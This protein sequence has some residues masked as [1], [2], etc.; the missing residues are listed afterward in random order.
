[1]SSKDVYAAFV[2]QL[3]GGDYKEYLLPNARE[4]LEYISQRDGAETMILTYGEQAFQDAKYAAVVMPLLA[5]IGVKA[6]YWSTPDKRKANF[7]REHLNSDG[8]YEFASMYGAKILQTSEIIGIGDERDDIIGCEDLPNYRAYCVK[9]PLDH[10]NRAWP[11]KD[12]L[13][14]N[15]CKLFKDLRDVIAAEQKIQST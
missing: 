11:T 5:G 6:S 2:E 9:S 14:R 15:H 8:E 13:E 12:E 4:L 10:S 7:Y 1:M 3:S